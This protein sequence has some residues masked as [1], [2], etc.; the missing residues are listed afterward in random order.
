MMWKA[1][2]GLVIGL[3]IGVFLVPAAYAKKSKKQPKGN[4]E[5][6]ATIAIG[7]DKIAR[8]SHICCDCSLSHYVKMRNVYY[9]G[10]D[11]SRKYAIEMTWVVDSEM[12]SKNRVKKFGPF[13][14]RQFNP[15]SA[16]NP[17]PLSDY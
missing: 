17:A 7:D 5:V 16:E 1:I 2:T 13:W 9:F 12:T 14:N 8:W 10:L 4:P 11:G 3:L 6:V 15:F